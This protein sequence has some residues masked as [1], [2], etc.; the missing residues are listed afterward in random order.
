MSEGNLEDIYVEIIVHHFI[1]Y[2]IYMCVYLPHIFFNYPAHRSPPPQFISNMF[3]E[4]RID[5]DLLSH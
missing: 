4:G 3:Q 5:A 1:F 2:F